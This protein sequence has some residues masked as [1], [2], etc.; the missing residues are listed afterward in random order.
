MHGTD[1][2]VD[3]VAGTREE[4]KDRVLT[5][6]TAA[7]VRS[8]SDAV[9]AKDGEPFFICPPDGQ[10]PCSDGHGYGL[11]HHECR[12]LGGYELA[13]AGSPPNPLAATEAAGTHLEL[14]LTN[15][16]IRMPDDRLI[17][18]EQLGITWSRKVVG[19]VPAL[20]DEI[21][22]RNYGREPVV[23]PIEV[24]FRADFKDVFEI[25]GLLRKKEGRRR[26][27]VWRQGRLD[28]SYAGA[29]GIDRW[30]R[31]T[32]DPEPG[33]R[34][35][36]AARF[37]IELP[38]RGKATVRITAAIDERQ[39][40]GATPIER[41]E[42]DEAPRGHTPTHATADPDASWIGAGSWT[43]SLRTTSLVLEAT[44]G[45]SFADLEL[46]RA[47]L[48]GHRYYEA[49]IPWFATLF[50]RDSLI[51]SLQTL[52]FDT[53]IAADTLRL[54]AGRQGRAVD[55]WRDEAPGKILHELRI[56]ELARLGEIPHS[57]Y[58]GT[59]DATPLFLI[60]LG[61]HAA[62]TGHDGLFRELAEPVEH[63]LGWLDRYADTDGDGYVD[64]QSH[65]SRGL[66]NQGW[67][68]SGDAIVAADGSLA[69]PPIA[70][71]EVQGY[72]YRAWL[73][74]A[75]LFERTGQADRAAG[76]RQRA[77]ELR[78]RFERDFWSDD[79]GCY[80]LARASGQDCEVLTSNPGHALW[81][82]IS[83]QDH[84]RWT[85]ERLMGPDMLNGWGIR[86][87]SSDAV[88]YHPI[89]YHLGTVWPHDN[90]I[91]AD[92]FRR[93]G[94]DEAAE[95]L[96]MGMIEAAQDF[97]H[98][99]LPE[100]FSGYD[101]SSYGVPVRYPVACHPQAWA[102]GAIPSMLVSILGLV[103]HAFDRRLEIHRP[104][105]PA[106][107]GSVELRGLRVGDGAAHIRVE[108]RGGDTVVDV[109][110]V[111]GDLDVRVNR[112]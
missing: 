21:E 39:R 55:E 105:L 95:R 109:V 82:G 98:A 35:S 49:G 20:E 48:D 106:F 92:G 51:T 61:R 46:L 99:M 104:R 78:D 23:F 27:P 64:Y 15:P 71:V 111:D 60:L 25:R 19:H 80:V 68:D 112:G 75:R 108:R 6:G 63:A 83:S 13:I 58:F 79:L 102:A 30:L 110:S 74:T 38:A 43:T 76:L 107:V 84:A 87:V 33:H 72:T 66:V 4:R 12:F 73:E 57:P 86:T 50:G 11:Y 97:P 89:G 36:D 17:R 7:I 31:L 77:S 1:R 47:R 54:L 62:W 101:R 16:D 40:R 3:A 59:V 37:S 24:R 56:G 8:I 81:S 93:Y 94:L 18:K 103:P 9:V 100:C 44:L 2:L 22:F 67:K 53:T 26:A 96:F 90:S 42:A 34:G 69:K 70:L 5:Q 29:D 88:A 85:A 52:A 10:V 45:R 91:I 65:T 28:F 32:F 14:E 41:R